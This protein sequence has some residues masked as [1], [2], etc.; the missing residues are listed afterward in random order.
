MLYLEATDGQLS[1][2]LVL[3]SAMNYALAHNGI[4]P[5]KALILRNDSDQPVRG[6]RLEVEL[7]APVAGRVAAPLLLDLPEIDH[8]DQ[9]SFT[10]RAPWAFDAA[11]FAQLDEAVMASVHARFYDSTRTLRAEGSLRLLARDEWWAESIKESLAAFVTPR[12]RAIQD[13]LGEAS[14]LLGQ[15]TGSPSM[16]GYQGGADR[17]MKIAN[18]IFDAMVAR[19]IR[20]INPPP[21]FEGTGQKIR[22]PREVLVD[23][24]GTCLDLATTYAAA[25]ELAGLNPVLVLC[26]GHAF[27]G[28]LLDEQQLPERVLTDSKMVLN[29]FESGLFIPVETTMLCAGDR[30]PTFAE[31]QYATRSRWSDV[32]CLIDVAAAHRFVRPIPAVTLEEGV[33][34]VEVERAASPGQAPPRPAVP[35]VPEAP[36]T[37]GGERPVQ[38]YPPRVARWRS[39][40]LDLSFRNPLLNMRAGRTSLDLH[41][42]QGALGTLEDLLFDGRSLNMIPDDQ[43]AEIHQAQGARTAQDMDPDALRVLLEG[44]DV[45]VACTAASFSSRLRGIQRRA[46][47]VSEETGTNNLF[48]TLGMLEWEDA[49]RQARAPLFLLP[50]TITARRGRGFTIQIDDGAYAAP[51]QCLLEKLRIAHGLS[52]PEFSDPQADVSGIDI[53]GALQAIRMAMVAAELPFAVEESA[54]VSLLQFSTL[55]LW[56]DLTENWETFM[57]NPV[58]RHLVETP[59]DSFVDAAAEAELPEDAEASSWCP[60]PIDGSQLEAVSWAQ[61]GRSFVLEGP[62]GTGKS[63]TITNLIANA[64]AAGQTVLFVA[65]KQAALDVV[66]RRLDK[67][68]LGN[69]CLDLHGKSRKPEDLRKQLRTS[70]H[71]QCPSN[72]E[73]WA[74]IR[75]AHRSSVVSLSRYPSALHQPGG[76]GLSAWRAR[77]SLITSGEGTAIDVPPAVVSA[78]LDTEALYADA[79]ELTQSLYDLGASVSTHPWRLSQLGSDRLTDARDRIPEAIAELGEALTA[80]AAGPVAELLDSVP[81]PAAPTSVAAWLRS[82]VD[83]EWRVDPASLSRAAGPEWRTELDA[84]RRRLATLGTEA[85]SL[86]ATFTPAAVTDLDLDDLLIRSKAADGKLFKGKA[87]KAVLADV[88]PV[89]ASDA[90]V[91]PSA[92]TPTLEALIALRSK[93][94]A[95]ADQAHSLSGVSLPEDWNPLVVEQARSV[96]AQA[97]AIQMTVELVARAPAALDI[98]A[99]AGAIAPSADALAMTERFRDAWGSITDLLESSEF[100]V[101]AWCGTDRSLLAAIRAD[102]PAWSSDATTG[103]LIGLGRWA[104]VYSHLAALN[105]AGLA[106]AQQVFDGSLHPDAIEPVLRRSIAR[107]VLAERLSTPALAGFDGVA[108]DRAIGQF[109]RAAEEMRRDMVAELPATIVA[110]RS[111]SPE[112]LIG[113]VGE[114]NR[115]LGRQR[116]GQKIR[117][118]FS[119]YGPIIAEITPCLMM[120][121]HSVARFLPAGAVDVDLVVFDEASQIRVA[122]AI[123]AMGRGKATV[124]VGDSQQMPPSNFAAVT[125]ATDD[126]DAQAELGIPADMESVLSEAVESNLPRLWLSWHYRSQHEALILFLQREVL[127]RSPRELPTPTG[128]ALRPRGQLA[129]GERHLRARG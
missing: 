52:I 11:T 109:A 82:V 3:E 112:R 13:L 40:L 128:E 100:A 81:G 78:P 121:P 108:H 85:T 37:R 75:A 26:P 28:H 10:M 22:E 123:G 115:E 79:R 56:Q 71:L 101:G 84:V 44:G 16:E 122:E 67:I 2:T 33:R 36:R 104:R 99:R 12:A 103:G 66:Q 39:S 98:L 46:R 19:G 58:V 50:I 45:F 129:A 62:P 120:S 111:F 76:A 8:H 72:A 35:R 49:G 88:A 93:T 97:A 127:R 117:E 92:I 106:I 34:V 116:G 51:N 20:Y 87:R 38:D 89:L 91:E 94:R 74:A 68:G 1:A 118:L 73:S 55:Q 60:I 48:V 95:A 6:L 21:S 42:P 124:V 83:A 64:L 24:W 15:R 7:T 96:E 61:A 119:N 31:A 41:V 90:R 105:A 114:L 32:I 125:N 9:Q 59:T 53:A 43:L 65:E 4:S 25:L 113:R 107:S 110:Q 77:Q 63:Q 23:R 70:L 14:D 57:Q 47:T 80:M 29:Y 18:A 102:L 126:E 17:A 69:L 54:H 30:T 86:L 5:L 27:S